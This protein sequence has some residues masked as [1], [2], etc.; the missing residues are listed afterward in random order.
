MFYDENPAAPPDAKWKMVAQWTGKSGKAG[1]Y[2]LKSADG[3]AF[4]PMY[5]SPSL[6]WSD[7]KN[8]MW[9][10]A[11]LGKYVVYIRIGRHKQLQLLFFV[12]R[13]NH[14]FTP[15]Q[16][17][18]WGWPHAPNNK[19]AVCADRAPQPSVH[20]NDTCTVWPGPGRSIGRC[21]IAADQ[22]HD[23]SLA[24]CSS[25]GTGATANVLTFE[26]EDPSCLDI[27][28]N[29]ATRYETSG[30]GGAILFFPSAYQ[31]IM[32]PPGNAASKNNNGLVDVRFA[33]ARHV[34][35]NCAYTPT[36]DGRSPFVPL[37]INRCPLLKMAPQTWATKMAGDAPRF[38]WCCKLAC[39][40]GL[41]TTTIIC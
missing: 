28:T 17:Q 12:L 40:V 5:D 22:L 36:R 15:Q 20:P 4:S 18:F 26:H 7:T 10:D 1:V 23:W 25:M 29:S 3:L 16:T 21:L 41:C 30:G 32:F 33:T 6:S 35:D 19:A 2:V 27:Y 11:E 13:Q 39:C 31:H 37:G 24:G 14:T 38:D 8:V 9:W 34:L